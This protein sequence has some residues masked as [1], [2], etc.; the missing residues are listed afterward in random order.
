MK[1]PT[2]ASDLDAVFATLPAQDNFW[3]AKL[4]DNARDT[5]KSKGALV[6]EVD[7]LNSKVRELEDKLNKVL[8]I[9]EAKVSAGVSEG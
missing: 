4:K 1:A 9:F 5:D 3:I 7:V 6:K 2:A 8:A